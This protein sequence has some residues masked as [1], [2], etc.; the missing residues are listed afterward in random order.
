[1]VEFRGGLKG[2]R[3]SFFGFFY[4]MFVT[5]HLSSS[6]IV[7]SGPRMFMCCGWM[8]RSRRTFFGPLFLNLLEPPLENKSTR[9]GE[10]QRGSKKDTEISDLE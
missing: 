6:G 2:A 1:M 9:R 7:Q 5:N 8:L 4:R 10:N 3:F